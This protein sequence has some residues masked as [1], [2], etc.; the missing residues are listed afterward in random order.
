MKSFG[1]LLMAAALIVP[2]AA[3][4]TAQSAGAAS[5]NVT[6][7]TNTGT[8]KL[9]PG[10]SLTIKHGQTASQK[11]GALGDCTGIGISDST[12]GTLGFQVLGSSPVSCK[13]IKGFTFIGPG[14]ILWDSAGSN[15][16]IRTLVKLRIHVDSL[17]QISF[18]GSVR[19]RGYLGGEKIKGTASIPPVLRSA[20]D[21]G[22]TCANSKAG[23]IRHLDYTN[24]SDFTIGV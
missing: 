9:N 8:V 10:V 17:T 19:G 23:R 6:C 1:R 21:N 16:G 7:T 12:S 15:G 11:A 24:T 2:A 20:G 14:S 4:V 3:V 5:D 22:G 13:S 18:S